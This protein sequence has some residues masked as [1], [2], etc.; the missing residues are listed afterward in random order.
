MQ[1]MTH[2]GWFQEGL[3]NEKFDSH[4]SSPEELPAYLRVH[5]PWYHGLDLLASLLLILLA[6]TEDPAVP[7]FRVSIA[8]KTLCSVLWQ[9]NSLATWLAIK[10]IALFAR[11]IVFCYSLI[12]FSFDTQWISITVLYLFVFDSYYSFKIH[13]FDITNRISFSFNNEISNRTENQATIDRD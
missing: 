12:I 4:P 7:A 13:H 3:N 6:F 2:S 9:P 11:P 8:Q 1:K 10:K 5:N